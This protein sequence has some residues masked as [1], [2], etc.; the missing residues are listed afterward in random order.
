[1]TQE[2]VAISA[3][4][5]VPQPIL[6]QV[7]RPVPAAAAPAITHHERVKSYMQVLVS[8]VSLGTGMVL[9]STAESESLRQLASGW[10]GLVIGFWLAD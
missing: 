2:P 5:P 8:L 1:M 3:T 9:V 6:E 7:A 10:V 4:P